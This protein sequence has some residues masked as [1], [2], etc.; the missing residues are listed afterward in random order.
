VKRRDLIK[1]VEQFGCVLLKEGAK[2]TLATSILPIHKS[3][4]QS[5]GIVK[6]MISWPERF[7]VNSEYPHLNLAKGLYQND[8]S[9]G[10]QNRTLMP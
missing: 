1:H 5:H 3:N 2:H 6:S 10:L 8:L 4:Q 7:A 9:Y